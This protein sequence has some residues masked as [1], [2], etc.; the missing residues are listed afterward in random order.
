MA[1]SKIT[2]AQ[3]EAAKAEVNAEMTRRNGSGPL[4]SYTFTDSA[5]KGD[6]I[7]ST[8]NEKVRKGLYNFINADSSLL[9]QAELVKGSKM[10][11]LN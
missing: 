6:H 11:S 4:T 9:T 7:K 3:F 2:A 8:E 1:Y 5:T 10:Q